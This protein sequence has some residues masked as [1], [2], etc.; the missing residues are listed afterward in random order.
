MSESHITELKKK[1]IKKRTFAKT[2]WGVNTY[3][4]WR[5]HRLVDGYDEQIFNANI[6][7]I[8][9]LT[10]ADLCHALCRF[11]PEI[12]KAK[13]GTE[14]PGKT[15]YELVI[16]IQ[17]HLNEN[18]VNWKLID[19]IEFSSVKVVLDNVMKERA[20]NNTGTVKKQAQMISYEYENELWNKSIL[21][22]DTPDKLRQTILFLIGIHCGLR[23]GDEHYDLRR[24]GL[25][26]M[27]QFTFQRNSLGQ[28]CVVYTEDTI[29]KTNDGGLDSIRKDRKVVW[30]YPGKDINRCPVRLID[31][32]ISLC[33]QVKNQ[34]QK[35][36]FYLHSLDRPNPAQWYSN[37]VVGQ[38]TLRNYVKDMLK[39]AELDGYFTNHS[40]R[41]TSTSRL[42]QAGVDRKLIK[43]FTGHHSDAVDQYQITSEKQRETIS[44]IIEGPSTGIVDQEHDKVRDSNAVSLPPSDQSDNISKCS[45]GKITNNCKPSNNGNIMNSIVNQKKGGKTIVKF[46]I[47]FINE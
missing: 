9:T 27:S 39:A 10:K 47:E 21:G 37:R 26:K 36:N 31:K 28:R 42:F 41:R 12:T 18:S 32:Y 25:D 33:P 13:D 17:R 40:L 16:S 11:I 4:E 30:I 29:T 14:Y 24:D 35:P 45:C 5:E 34:K 22:E 1:Q 8:D 19:D 23:A 20:K 2:K 3:N 44:N 38:N 7:S 43:E 46:E 6:E 15:L